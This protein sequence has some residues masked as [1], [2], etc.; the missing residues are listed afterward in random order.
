MRYLLPCKRTYS[1]TTLLGYR[2]YDPSTGRF[3][4]QDPAQDANN[5]YDYCANNPLRWADPTG[6]APASARTDPGIYNSYQPPAP[7]GS[8]ST[9]RAIGDFL[10]SFGTGL[11]FALAPEAGLAA[12]LGGALFEGV[13]DG[14]SEI[15]DHKRPQWVKDGLKGAFGGSG[16]ALGKRIKNS[17]SGD[18]GN[19]SGRDGGTESGQLGG[20]T[21]R[22]HY[23]EPPGAVD[24]QP[25]LF[26]PGDW[27]PFE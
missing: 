14:V 4:T 7:V 13:G 25:S 22:Q 17:K 6:H 23:V 26:K 10:I 2:Y 21:G 16:A 19:P 18:N 3:I 11:A 20:G 8:P 12:I 27:P 15:L 5:W 9:Y 1:R 24:E